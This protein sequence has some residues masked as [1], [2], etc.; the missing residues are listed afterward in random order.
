MERRVTK[1]AISWIFPVNL[2][3]EL[4]TVTIMSKASFDLLLAS[5]STLWTSGQGLPLLACMGKFLHAE[6]GGTLALG[7]EIVSSDQLYATVMY[8]NHKYRCGWG[9]EW[10]EL[11]ASPTSV[12]NSGHKTVFLRPVEWFVDEQY[13]FAYCNGSK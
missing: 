2:I 9:P 10:S 7:S 13:V 1:D 3:Q 12:V 8:N 5:T 11:N 6:W 4:D